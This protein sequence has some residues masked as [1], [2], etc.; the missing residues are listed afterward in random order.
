MTELSMLALGLGLGLRHAV[1]P[2]HLAVITSL[3]QREREPGQALRIAA[4]WG[5]GHTAAFLAVGLTVVLVGARVPAA[6]ETATDLLVGGMLIGFGALNLRSSL[7]SDA[8]TGHAHP[9]RSGAGGPLAIGTVHGL[10]GS[11]GV[12][13][14]ATTT[15]GA[16]STA[17]AYLALFGM[18]TV[19]GMMALTALLSRPL[20]WTVRRGRSWGRRV[21]VTAATLSVG[22][23]IRFV[24]KAV[25]R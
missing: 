1:D 15:I 10:A 17:V 6:F 11:A 22:L 25:F 23:G 7:G 18:G 21:G 16:R 8:R 4:L 24:V 5:A 3:L 14:L 9:R 13:L 19:F 12:A 20:G 2:D